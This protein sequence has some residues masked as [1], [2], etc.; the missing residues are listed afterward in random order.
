MKKF[1][2]L[3]PALLLAACNEAQ[4]EP[5]STASL[6]T[7]V[8]I[9]DVRNGSILED[10][11]MVIDSGK[12]IKILQKVSHPESYKT[13]IDGMGSYALPGLA[14]M[15]A[16]IPSPDTP[17]ERIEET[18]FLYLSSGITTI[19]GM[20][21]HP[22][23]LDMREAAQ[24]GTLLSP[25][26]FTSSPSLNGTT[27]STPEEARKKVLQYKEEG[28]D[29]LKIHPGIQREVFDSLVKT[30]KAADMAF[31]GHVPVAV[32]IRHALESQY[33]SIDHV[34]GFLEGLVPGA[35][36]TDPET[37][38]FFGYNFTPLADTTLIAELVSLSRENKVWIVPTQSLF[39]RWFA[40]VSADELL[41]QPEMKYM[42]ATTL[43]DWKRR[44]EESTG[45]GSGFSEEQWITFDLIR[46]K[47]INALQDNGHGILL[48]S[49][50]PQLFNVPGFSIHHEIEGMARAGLS[51]LEIVQSGTISPARFFGKEGEFGELKEGM[52][53]DL[54]LVNGNPLNDLGALKDLNGV[55][56]RGHWLSREAINKR[57]AQIAANAINH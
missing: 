47:L 41:A 32:G 28:Y 30:A 11:Q 25:R 38:G 44:K 56:V 31:S 17:R 22:S 26:I 48:G 14:E 37:N 51:P 35:K 19:R 45:P 7:N 3:I 8:N 15:H 2:M 34:D 13:R 33:A 36:Q 12:I 9:I 23:H 55:M 54:I 50:A 6:I 20:L 29:F 53:A 24:K 27:V 1:H 21:G 10:H 4:Q 39:E 46:K 52:A 49:D 5:G 16:H 57:L 42:P 40:P 18:L 43:E